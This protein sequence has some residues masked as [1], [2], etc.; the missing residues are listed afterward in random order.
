M[1]LRNLNQSRLSMVVVV[2]LPPVGMRLQR[3]W[4]RRWAAEAGVCAVLI[5]SSPLFRH[6]FVPGRCAGF[7]AC[8]SSQSFPGEMG[9]TPPGRMCIVPDP[10]L[11]GHWC[12]DLELVGR[13]RNMFWC[14]SWAELQHKALPKVSSVFLGLNADHLGYNC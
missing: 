3:K 14:W 1:K 5:L 9:N 8:W 10:G 4:K 11:E 7:I 12:G 13:D 6:G 2:M